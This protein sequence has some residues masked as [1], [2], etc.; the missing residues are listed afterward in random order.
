MFLIKDKTRCIQKKI[1][2][3]LA[4]DL[5]SALN[6]A[7]IMTSSVSNV[8]LTSPMLSK[9]KRRRK[10][11][12]VSD[13]QH[14]HHIEASDSTTPDN[15]SEKV[16]SRKYKQQTVVSDGDN[17]SMRMSTFEIHR[18]SLSVSFVSGGPSSSLVVGASE[19]DSASQTDDQRRRRRPFKKPSIPS[20]F[21]AGTGNPIKFSGCSPMKIS[22]QTMARSMSTPVRRRRRNCR[23]E[24][25]APLATGNN[26]EDGDDDLSTPSSLS[27]ISVAI[28]TMNYAGKRKRSRAIHEDFRVRNT[29]LHDCDM[30]SIDEANL[31]VPEHD[32]NVLDVVSSL[33]HI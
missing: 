25:Y 28:N 7:S 2:D 19:S 12:I 8:T 18:L 32:G 22:N 29:C 5:N 31:Y 13:L 21:V 10:R 24:S 11:P 17:A 9:S 26:D 30:A 27:S 4:A 1:M 20:A 6:D 15:S 14:Q 16:R 3:Q 23:S 33:V